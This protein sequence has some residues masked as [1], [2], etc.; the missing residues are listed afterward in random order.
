MPKYKLVSGI[1]F[2]KGGQDGEDI[3]VPAGKTVDLDENDAKGYLE[4]GSIKP[5]DENETTEPSKKE[6]TG[7]IE[8]EFTVGELHY[9]KV[10][11]AEGVHYVLNGDEV[12]QDAFINAYQ[13]KI[14]AEEDA[15]ALEAREKAAAEQEARTPAVVPL[16]PDNPNLSNTEQV[17]QQHTLDNQIVVS[18]E[19][20]T[21]A[22]VPMLTPE[23]LARDFDQ[24]QSQPSG[25]QL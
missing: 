8:H 4:R 16:E 7:D 5:L 22:S 13:A 12:G 20:A 21:S 25:V 17:L 9:Q 1:F 18:T 23:D 14:K 11:N 24:T 15:K 10:L 2:P 3:T 19:Q 6:I